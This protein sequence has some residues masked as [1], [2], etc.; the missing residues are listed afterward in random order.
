MYGEESIIRWD[1]DVI[2]FV[3]SS[4]AAKVPRSGIKDAL[5]EKFGID[6]SMRAVD[7]AISRYCGDV[8]G[9][10]A[11]EV[12][13]EREALKARVLELIETGLTPS[14]AADAMGLRRSRVYKWFRGRG[15]GPA[16]LRLRYWLERFETFP[17][18]DDPIVD[19]GKLIVDLG[20]DD[21]RWP[22]GK[23]ADGQFRF[24]GCPF[25]RQQGT[26]S[27]P[28]CEAHAELDVKPPPAQSVTGGSR[29]RWIKSAVPTV[30]ALQ[31]PNGDPIDDLPEAA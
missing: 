28:Y 13:A 27:R 22:I 8:R 29:A 9:S 24:C 4:F 11:D 12:S 16:T 3:R 2:E 6:A 5:R 18:P 17:V 10:L 25:H 31:L 30:T 7:G 19:G 15:S 26:K 20:S 21:C 23:D 14:E 1:R